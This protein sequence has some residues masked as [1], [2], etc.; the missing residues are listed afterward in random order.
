MLLLKPISSLN[1]PP[2]IF[3][4]P[5]KPV[6]LLEVLRDANTPVPKS[7]LRVINFPDVVHRVP[8]GAFK[9]LHNCRVQISLVI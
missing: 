7:P 4:L 9:R 6:P 5:M 1:V 2:R 3:K 8:G